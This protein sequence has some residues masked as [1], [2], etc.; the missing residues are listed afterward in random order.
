MRIPLGRLTLPAITL[1]A[2]TLV[3]GALSMPAHAETG[4][5][6][7][8]A[9]TDAAADALDQVQSILADPAAADADGRDLTLALRD[10]RIR[11]DQ[12]S[13]TDRA[14]ASRLLSRPPQV[15]GWT[16]EQTRA[17]GDNVL[18]HWDNGQATSDFVNDA[19][20]VAEHVLATY[21]AAGYRAPMPDGTAG[22][23]SRLDIYLVDFS[24]AG[25]QG[26][27]GF[28]DGSVAPPRN[29]PYNTPAYCAFDH[30]FSSF[31]ALT[32]AQNLR[33]T[34]AHELFHATQFA[35]DYYEDAWFMEAT[36]TWAEDEVYDDINDNRQYLPLS[37]LAQPRQ[38]LDQFNSS[39]L[40]QYGEWIFF[41]YLSERFS[42]S[43]GGLP[44][45]VR[46][47]W[48]RAD[49][50]R[51]TQHDLYSIRAV[52]KELAS[53]GTDLRRVYAQFGDANRRP[54]RAYEE[55]SHYRAAGA[56]HTWTFTP[57]SHDTRWKTSRVDHLATSTLAVKPSASMKRWRL[58]VQ[59]DLPNRASGVAAIVTRYDAK[60]RPSSKLVKLSKSGN[61]T[62]RLP[63]DS[64]H[65]TR[66]DVTLS[67]A[68]IRYARCFSGP[69]DGV[70]YSCSGVP[71]DDN[72]PM[73]YRISAIR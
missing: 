5:P 63:F 43:Q 23:D 62:M 32:P 11:Q 50:T 55:G 33:V 10:L 38:S 31:P 54:A 59:V 42:K 4:N 60:G 6:E 15:Y 9:S 13:R 46:R 72:R 2:A 52:S 53:Q 40:R 26:L 45:I 44:V 16:N 64:R 73:R 58:R 70:S 49:S 28:C 29:G 25:Q 47:I 34:A 35:Y 69:V 51:G 68:G 17:F 7:P 41:R 71:K 12:L 67:N 20:N 57:R 24:A 1:L 65:L 36:A 21:K 19:G 30:N 56:A 3:G 14:Q 37:P 48:Q 22:G 27:Y 8:T 66:V 18:V 61:A 39:S